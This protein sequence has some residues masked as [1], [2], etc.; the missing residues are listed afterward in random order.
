M[1]ASR[2]QTLSSIG[3][4]GLLRRIRR[5]CSDGK[6][7]SV[8]L[9]DDA[10]VAKMSP[11]SGIVLTTDAMIEG[12]H[13]HLGWMARAGWPGNAGWK[14]LGR[15]AMAI[16]L[17]DL[18]SMGKVRPR[19]A[20]ITLGLSGDISVDN[21]DNLYQGFGYWSRRS[22]FSIV[23]GDIIRSDKSIISITLVGD[24][25]GR[26]PLIRSGARP[27]DLLCSTGPLGRSAAGLKILKKQ[28]KSAQ[29]W[30]KRLIENHLFPRP[31][32]AEGAALA[33]EDILA[34]SALD[35]S[36]DL[37]TSLGLLSA[38][39]GVGIEVDLAYAP[40]HPDLARFAAAE[41]KSPYAFILDGGEDY[42]LLFTVPEA[43][44]KKVRA[45]IPSAQILGRVTPKRAGVRILLSGR[46]YR[47]PDAR[48]R[49]F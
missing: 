30:Q 29:I 36:D 15:K 47:G 25:E 22:G 11:S 26:R 2:P 42:E 21:V 7:A 31:R 13:F 19:F 24:L 28:E 6:S 5:W 38:A 33:G 35:S 12:T 20:L 39:S 8:P 44:W 9:G 34:S 17:S 43:R 16:N 4:S 10:F 45:R 3:E 41:R 18:A 14:A 27:G 49:H 46:P 40:V 32:T 48:F 1:T 37:R 23:G